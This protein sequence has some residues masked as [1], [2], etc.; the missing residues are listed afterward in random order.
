MANIHPPSP[1]KALVIGASSGYGAG[2]AAALAAA[3][4]MVISAARRYNGAD[5]QHLHVDVT[6]VGSVDALF[7]TLDQLVGTLDVVVYSAGVARGLRTVEQGE[8][9]EYAQVFNTNA[10]GLYHVARRAVPMLKPRRGYL[11]HI[12]S[13]ATTLAYEGGA[14]YCASKAAATT[15]VRT[16]RA[17]LLGTGVRTTSIEPG[18]GDT[19]FQMARYDGDEDRA[20]KHYAGIRQLSPA[21]L[22][23]TVLWLVSR[24][25]HINIDEITI[26]PLDQLT[27]G[28]TAAKVDRS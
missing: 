25:A 9:R 8:P 3:G 15:I 7:D 5:P 20:R 17:E 11:L 1:P 10:V 18:L 21:D 13:I 14:D 26:K 4:Y 16:L 27:H 28:K 19:N 6:D 12:G 23:E 2:I 24:P 22:G